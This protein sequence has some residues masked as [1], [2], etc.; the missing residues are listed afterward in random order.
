MLFRSKSFKLLIIAGLI[1][2]SGQAKALNLDLTSWGG[3]ENHYI[4]QAVWLADSA[5]LKG[6]LTEGDGTRDATYLTH[7]AIE[8]IP[9][10]G[11]YLTYQMSVPVVAS[12]DNSEEKISLALDTTAP[13][14]AVNRFKLGIIADTGT[15]GLDSCSVGICQASGVGYGDGLAA[16]GVGG[17]FAGASG[18]GTDVGTI[19]A[20]GNVIISSPT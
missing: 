5:L 13:F 12:Q 1:A 4:A 19:I 17:T 8:L 20:E 16:A 6:A 2:I 9:D 14:E 11:I 10:S 18:L 3:P 7:G 15:T